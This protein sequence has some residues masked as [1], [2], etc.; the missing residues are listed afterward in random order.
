VP[1]YKDGEKQNVDNCRGITWLI[2]VGKLYTSILNCRTSSWVE[3]EK[4]LIEEQGGFRAKRST[5]EQSLLKETI[6]ARRRQKK[7]TFCYFLDIRRHVSQ[8][9][10]KVYGRVC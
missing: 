9:L 2:V 7:K 5:S 4:K 3:R 1:I 10:E 6:L 8:S